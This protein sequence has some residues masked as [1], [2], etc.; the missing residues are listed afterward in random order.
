VHDSHFLALHTACL[1][2]LCQMSNCSSGTCCHACL[3]SSCMTHI[4]GLCHVQHVCADAKLVLLCMFHVVCMRVAHSRDC[5]HL[6]PGGFRSPDCPLPKPQKF[7]R[8]LGTSARASS[9]GLDSRLSL[10]LGSIMSIRYSSVKISI[11]SSTLCTTFI[12]ILS[13]VRTFIRIF[14]HAIKSCWAT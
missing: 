1:A 4:T 9:L 8:G 10:A 3:M 11:Y 2:T 5:L 7:P 12:R 13:L 14:L 6:L